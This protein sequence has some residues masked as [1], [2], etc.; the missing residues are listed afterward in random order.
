MNGNS[1][2]TSISYVL[3]HDSENVAALTVILVFA[4]SAVKAAPS[5]SCDLCPGVSLE[6]V[7]QPDSAAAPRLREAE[8]LGAVQL[9]RTYAERNGLSGGA[10][11]R[12]LK[13]LKVGRVRGFGSSHCGWCCCC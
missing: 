11:E 13:I 7:I 8:T 4:D 1:G 3:G 10:Q 5:D 12:G 9:F 2:N 6:V